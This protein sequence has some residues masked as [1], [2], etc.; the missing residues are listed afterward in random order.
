MSSD[1]LDPT[2]KAVTDY[3][4]V[5]EGKKPAAVAEVGGQA[6]LTNEQRRRV[7]YIIALWRL[8]CYL[9]EADPPCRYFLPWK[10]NDPVSPWRI[11][12]LCEGCRKLE[13]VEQRIEAELREEL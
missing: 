8:P 12:A 4:E 11:T 9:C 10:T 3:I 13:D 6:E 2:G 5:L 7:P 1:E